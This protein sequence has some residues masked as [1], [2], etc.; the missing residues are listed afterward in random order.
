MPT[1]KI[2]S[3]ELK[4]KIAAGE[5][6][7]RPA[8][9][10]KELVENSLDAGASAIVVEIQR[11]GKKLIR[12][13]D[14]GLGMDGE[15]ALMCLQ[16]H[17]TSKLN[18]EEDLF[19]VRTMGFRGEALPSI[20]SVSKLTLTTAPLK[21]ISGV[22]L[23]IEGGNV[24]V[25]RE[26]PS[27]G[28]T[29]EV[30]ELFFNTPARKKFLKRD[31]T[32]LIHIVDTL[33]RE[34]LS[35]PEVAFNLKVDGKETMNVSRASSKRER[36]MQIYG[37]EFIEGLAEVRKEAGGMSVE[38][39]VSNLRGLRDTRAHQFIFIN[40]RPV[41]DPSLSHATYAAYNETLPK[42]KHPVFFV[43]LEIDPSMVDFNVHPAKRE[44]RFQ[45]KEIAY[46]F[47][48]G[49]VSDI[50]RIGPDRH[51]HSTIMESGAG[52]FKDDSNKEDEYGASGSFISTGVAET[53]ELEYRAELPFIYLG[54]TFLALAEGGGLTLVDH[55]AAHE[56]VLYEKFLGNV[57][58]GSVKLLFPKQVKL[59]PKEYM[60]VMKHSE[61]L[62][63]F[64]IE[65]E[66]FGHNTVSIRSM[67]EVM[68]EADLRGVLSD[69]AHQLDAKVK[70][71]RSLKE[72][73]A[74]KIACHS[75]VRGRK[76]LSREGLE[77]LLK[78]LE[79]TSDPEHCP[80][81]RP[82]RLHFTP[83]DLKKMFKRK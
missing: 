62:L 32:E 22:Q 44:V 56:R 66:D 60:L 83:E 46:R 3:D 15:D 55:H 35:N 65:V 2:L 19:R 27:E 8:S 47:L 42:D 21:A 64:G 75:S 67:P 63:E 18:S 81:G 11:G 14:N 76:V 29:V 39:F 53:I 70:P 24:R 23:E 79:K 43:F 13:S 1:I 77:K 78:D 41:R 45:D 28:T 31:S 5:V 12:V 20:A 26:A 16:R 51:R 10:V 34:S 9:V 50:F 73:V 33:T 30:R 38:A 61:M 52:V 37:S 59:S 4:N 6:V 40:G 72:A 49:A 25:E 7:E 57:D 80:H 17:A 69:A 68:D 58:L 54:D 74:A 71:G 36:L 48:R 82:T